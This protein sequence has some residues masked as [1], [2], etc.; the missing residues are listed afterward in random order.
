MKLHF[1]LLTN[2]YFFIGFI[3]FLVTILT[4]INN[5]YFYQHIERSLERSSKQLETLLESETKFCKKNRISNK[6]YREKVINILTDFSKY[7]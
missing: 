4:A 1:R 5:F 6:R 7:K 2:K 3:I